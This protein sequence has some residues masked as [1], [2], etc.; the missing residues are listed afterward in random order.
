MMLALILVPLAVA[1]LSLVLPWRLALVLNALGALTTLAL[2]GV[3]AAGVLAGDAPPTTLRGYLRGDDL[4]LTLAVVVSAAASVAAC[5]GVASFGAA[6]DARRYTV[7][8]AA[9]LWALLST[10]LAD[11]LG[12]MWIT[13]ELS[14]VFGAF[15]VGSRGDKPALEAAFK[16]MILGSVGLVIGLLATALVHRVGGGAGLGAGDGALSFLRLRAAG[17]ALTSGPLRIAFALAVAG[18]G[19]KVGL[20][21]LHVWKPDAYAAAPAPVTALLAGAAVAVPL[22]A[23]LRFGALA[24][25]AGEGALVSHVFVTLGLGSLLAATLLAARERD[26]RRI[27]AFTSV[28]HMG[29]ILLACGLEPD[30]VRGGLLHLLTNGTLKA[31]AFGLLGFVVSARGSAD[32]R[33]GPGLYAG[34]PALAAV[35]LVTMA[36]ALGFPPFGMFA[37]ELTVLRALFAAD[38]V[39]VGLLVTLVLAVIF[40]V[41]IAATLRVV[42]ARADQPLPGPAAHRTAPLAIGVPVL[43]AMVW[44][45]VGLPGELWSQLGD[46]ARGL[47]P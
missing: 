45:G 34:S 2:A 44:V 33:S 17:H 31:L 28:E 3:L 41:V 5:I 23:I 12:V 38:H 18:Y 32:S 24:S 46:V 6:R 43:L 42:F 14:A 26:F 1:L 36:A 29:L 40:G 8:A 9:L 21:P 27:L 19:L 22:G 39:V 10:T 47:A 4:G 7:L 11:H 35:F 15:L 30:A 37:S 13:M 16:Y 20:F 25:A